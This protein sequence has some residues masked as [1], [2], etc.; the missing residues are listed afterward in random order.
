MTVNHNI[1][2]SLNLVTLSNLEEYLPEMECVLEFDVKTVAF[3]PFDFGFENTMTIFTEDANVIIELGNLLDFSR[4]TAIRIDYI[5]NLQY[6]PTW[7]AELKLKTLVIGHCEHLQNIFLCIR[8]PT[9][10]KSLTV[11]RVFDCKRFSK[12]DRK[13]VV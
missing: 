6:F 4:V 10:T 5:L 11:F 12:L 9:F 8:N 7:T 3:S 13:S 1:G 2:D